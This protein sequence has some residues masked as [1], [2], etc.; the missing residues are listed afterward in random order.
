MSKIAS[1]IFLYQHCRQNI[2]STELFFSS[3]FTDLTWTYFYSHRNKMCRQ[4][5]FK[6]KK[7][8]KWRTGFHQCLFATVVNYKK[9]KYKL[10]KKGILQI[11]PSTELKTWECTLQEKKWNLQAKIQVQI[12]KEKKLITASMPSLAESTKISAQETTSG[13]SLSTASLIVSKYLKFLSPK[14]LS[15]SFSLRD[16]LVESS[17]NDASQD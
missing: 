12:S 2:F 6:E 16:L 1:H 11:P 14:L 3:S 15:C 4:K 5:K 7:K 13:H 9:E 10:R 8:Q 17:N